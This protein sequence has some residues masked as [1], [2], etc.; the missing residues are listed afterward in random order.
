M[1]TPSPSGFTAIRPLLKRIGL[2]DKETE[3]YL[4]VLSLKVARAS[5]IAKVAKQERSNTYLL[6]R[7]LKEKGLIS[8]VERGKVIHFIAEPPQRLL[9]YVEMQE[10]AL[11]S[12]K[13]LIDGILPMLSSLTKPLIG[14]PRVTMLQG[15]T[16]M[17]QIYKDCL[18]QDI[19]GLF[20]P[21]AMYTAF[22]ENIVTMV[23]GKHPQMH[24]RDLLVDG[25]GAKRYMKEIPQDE[26][27]NIR[28]LPKTITFEADTMIFGDT[29][30][31][32]AYDDERTIVRIENANIANAFRAWFELMW[33]ISKP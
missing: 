22:G 8:E 13:P 19:C 12:L 21:T 32:I 33:T 7:S 20:N 16:G 4:S 11:R 15:E 31:L 1:T 29:V 18:H 30:A 3:I 14:A 5:T 23:L 25:P 17:R 6:L 10:L 9:Q 26:Y 24:G 28:I 27:Y 2:D